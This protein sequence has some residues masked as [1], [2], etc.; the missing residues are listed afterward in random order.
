MATNI[1]KD[2]REL[3]VAKLLTRGI[4]PSE[5]TR[6]MAREYKISKRTVDRHIARIY[7]IWSKDF[8]V[9]LCQ[10]L[11]YHKAMRMEI[12][13]KAYLNRDFRTCL[14]V[15]QDIA[16]LEG[17]YVDEIRGDMVFNVKVDMPEGFDEEDA[18]SNTGKSKPDESKEHN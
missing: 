15:M 9:K 5:I 14:S 3:M 4:K 7:K 10:G 17:L 2:K 16:K 13:Q 18:K 11:P 12:Y 6:I 1:E 8:E